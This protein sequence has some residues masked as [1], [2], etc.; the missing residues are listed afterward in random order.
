MVGCLHRS[1]RGWITLLRVPLL[2][3]LLLPTPGC[4]TGGVV[5]WLSQ[6]KS[7]SGSTNSLPV[8]T[9]IAITSPASGDVVFGVTL[10]DANSN[11]V[12]LTLEVITLA[13]T[14]PVPV[15][16]VIPVSDITGAQG[17]PASPTGDTHRV[18]WDSTGL[19]P[20]Q[21]EVG[22]VLRVIPSDG[23]GVPGTAGQSG[24]FDIS[25]FDELELNQPGNSA[26]DVGLT[27]RI[28]GFATPVSVTDLTF[29]D[30]T[31]TNPAQPLTLRSGQGVG[32]LPPGGQPLS[33]TTV[34]DSLSDIGLGNNILVEVTVTVSDGPITASRTTVPFFVSNGPLD[35]HQMFPF[36]VQPDGIAVGDVTGDG[37]PD[38]VTGAVFELE[39]RGRISLLKNESNDFARAEVTIV[40][41][42]PGAL[43]PG[44]PPTAL[45]NHFLY[46]AGHPSECVILDVN[47]D[48]D[49]DLVAADSLYA[50]NT[51]KFSVV[52]T[53]ANLTTAIG[54]A[55]ADPARAL[56][57]Q[58]TLT[59]LSTGSGLSVPTPADYEN[60]AAVLADMAPATNPGA[61]LPL[62]GA[63]AENLNVGWFRQDL[64]AVDLDGPGAAGNGT[65]DLVSVCGISQ[66]GRAAVFGD[67]RGAVVIRQVDGAG[68]L[69]AQTWYLDPSNMGL[70]PTHA[71][72][73]D[74][75]RDVHLTN[76]VPLGTIAPDGTPDIIVAN[77]WD[78]SL[79]FYPADGG[80]GHARDHPPDVRQLQLAIEP[81]LHRCPGGGPPGHRHHRRGDRRPER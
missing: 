46:A 41:D 5:G 69:G 27:Y 39:D 56:L 50:P 35:D 53:P 65:T 71:A 19:F 70:V 23:G 60:N 48:G 3:A 11:A 2:L 59:V 24:P 52:T 66:L 51:E 44:I 4:I 42:L 34:W 81:D 9:G 40:P 12:D 8:A 58:K 75:T 47:G 64:L 20:G 17:L 61:L 22:V 38:A 67:L 79:T 37:L 36:F 49:G 13:G 31:T 77:T 1:P 33:A 63:G 30:L 74:V 72:V 7:S 76:P 21:N 45:D 78:N 80:R 43:L 57:H 32:V 26:F 15:T 18:T 10:I 25:P 62:G 28:R 6:S 68:N 14:P 29:R 55:M 73:A 54:N 16:Q